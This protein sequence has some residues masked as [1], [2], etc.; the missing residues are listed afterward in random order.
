MKLKVLW[1]LF[2]NGL[3]QETLGE[4]HTDFHCVRVHLFS[5][6]SP[7]VKTKKHLTSHCLSGGQPFLW[8]CG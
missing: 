7:R 4:T 2:T 8:S 6:A 1:F 5:R 3:S